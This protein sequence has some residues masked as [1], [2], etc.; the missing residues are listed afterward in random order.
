MPFHHWETQNFKGLTNKR[1]KN[2]FPFGKEAR[3]GHTGQTEVLIDS[4]IDPALMI[5]GHQITALH[6]QIQ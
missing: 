6:I 4:S 5:T 2:K 1:N 3:Q